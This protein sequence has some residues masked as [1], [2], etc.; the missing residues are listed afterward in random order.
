M[1]TVPVW[2]AICTLITATGCEIITAPDRSQIAADADGDNIDDATDN[3]P[4]I[5]NA[6]QADSDDDGTGD[7]CTEALTD[8]DGDEVADTLDNCPD[9]ANADQLDTDDDD[10]GDTC[11]ADDD[12]DGLSDAD[13]AEAGTDPLDSDSD[14]DSYSDNAELQ[15]GS[16]PLDAAS[17]PSNVDDQDGDGKVDAQDNC[18]A[19]ANANQLDTDDDE[20]G[21]A[22][23]A[24]D[25]NDG[26]LDNHDNC[27]LTAN[28]N[29]ANNDGDAQGDLCDTNDDNDAMPDLS[30]PFPLDRDNDTIND[31]DD[32]CKLTANLSQANFDED[33]NGDA[34]DTDDDNDG[35]PDAQD[36][37]PFDPSE[38]LD[39][40]GDTLGNNADADDDNDGLS[41]SQESLEGSDPLLTDTDSDGFSD[42]IEVAAGTDPDDAADF[43]SSV[44]DQD[45]DGRV[46]ALDNCPQ[47][48][49]VNQYNH[50]DDLLGDACDSDDDNDSVSDEQEAL[51]GSNPI[52]VDTDADGLSDG[53]E[54]LY[55]TNPAE[56][57][58]DNDLLHD[59][60]EIDLLT[61]PLDPDTD[62]DAWGDGDEVNFDTDP[63]NPNSYPGAP[64][65]DNDGDSLSNALE[66]AIGTNPNDADS[67]NDNWNDALEYAEGTDPMDANDYPGVDTDLD[68]LSDA[69][70]NAYATDVS[71]TDTDDDGLSDGWEVNVSGTDPLD[72][73][74]PAPDV[75]GDGLTE[76]QENELGTNPN[77]LDTDADGI[78]DG[79]ESGYGTDATVADTDGD[80]HSDGDEVN[81][82]WDP[83]VP[84]SDNDGLTND[85]EGGY[86]TDPFLSDS[87]A[88]GLTDPDELLTYAT[89]A[90][91][92]DSDND[93]YSDGL[94]VNTYDTDPLNPYDPDGDTDADGLFDNLESSYGT[95]V[96]D[97]D[98]DDDGLN[99]GDEVFGYS[100]DP[101]EADTDGD[102][103][104]D[105]AE[106]NVHN[107]DPLDP[108]DYPRTD[109]FSENG[110]YSCCYEHGEYLNRYGID[111]PA[112][113][114]GWTGAF[115]HVGPV[116]MFTLHTHNDSDIYWYPFT[117]AT[118][119]TQIGVATGDWNQAA[120][121]FTAAS[122][123]A[124]YMRSSG[125]WDTHSMPQL[126]GSG[127]Q[128]I[129]IHDTPMPHTYVLV[130]TINS[131][132]C[133]PDDEC[134]DVG[135]AV[136]I[137]GV[138]PIFASEVTD[139]DTDG[140]FANIETLY[141]LSDTNG[142]TDGDA[143]GD[144]R[145]L[146]DGAV[147]DDDNDGLALWQELQY[148]T[149]PTDADT[150]DDTLNDGDEVLAGYDPTSATSPGLDT[151]SDGLYDFQEASYGGDVSDADTDNDGLSDGDEVLYGTGV[152]VPDSDD[153]GL[154][155]SNEVY[156]YSTNPLRS[157][158][159]YDGWSDYDEVDIGTDPLNPRDFYG[160]LAWDDALA[161][162]SYCCY[163][164][165]YLTQRYPYLNGNVP[166]PMIGWSGL[167]V[168][169]RAQIG[170]YSL[171]VWDWNGGYYSS[172]SP[173]LLAGIQLPI[174]QTGPGP[175]INP[176]PAP[177]GL[178]EG[179]TSSQPQ[180]NLPAA[181][182]VWV[183]PTLE[184]D[185][186]IVAFVRNSCS[187]AS[188][189]YYRG[190][191]F[192]LRGARPL[193]Y[194]QTDDSD[195]DQ[196]LNPAE[197][198]YGGATTSY[199]TDGDGFAD[200][201]EAAWGGDLT[202]PAIPGPDT[203]G[204]Y[205]ADYFEA[206]F[207]T[208]VDDMD[209]D[210]DGL[211]DADEVVLWHSNPLAGDSDGDGFSDAVEVDAGMDPG[212]PHDSFQ[213]APFNI[214]DSAY[215]GDYD[216]GEWGSRYGLSAYTLPPPVQGWSG[217]FERI[218]TVVRTYALHT[219]NG[220]TMYWYSPAVP[221]NQYPI[222][223]IDGDST[224]G[225]TFAPTQRFGMYFD[226]GYTWQ[227]NYSQYALGHSPDR[228][229]WLYPT[230][231]ADTWVVA[232][233][234]DDCTSS[235]Q[236]YEMAGSWEIKGVRPLLGGQVLDG[237]HDGLLDA[238]EDILGTNKA[239]RDSDG[240]RIPD[241]VEVILH[242][243]PLDATAD[244]DGD[245][246]SDA[247]EIRGNSTDPTQ[248]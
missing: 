20:A 71:D 125:Y 147:G 115:R 55:G 166:A 188:T 245:G 204:D 203:D 51:D 195:D 101:L 201:F 57:D 81:W 181:E 192:E 50:D 191:V 167:L 219:H 79:D 95:D 236:C 15:A 45:S 32:N 228:L 227:N 96:S 94:E 130:Y 207:G 194:G 72:P 30:D 85:E 1:R 110:P 68:G 93:S 83:L 176:G 92:S 43:P 157:D 216:H 199:D 112:P 16:D 149:D 164:T 173:N 217:L 144:L 100:T 13:E 88:D 102:T 97:S 197:A 47:V 52:V 113:M 11:D 6:D 109:P 232:V 174:D 126:N 3:C 155:D 37:F 8:A 66:A 240:D 122:Q 159:D 153:D 180:L 183:Y 133:L 2:V 78:W 12:N 208:Y 82:G 206:Q 124:I 170:V 239:S 86:G 154:S 77:L 226:T 90:T 33:A 189:C 56:V 211:W 187:I 89:F 237:D 172:E 62:A 193:S 233:A 36:A 224:S 76:A 42:A 248:P 229:V 132:S 162:N 120:N 244:T 171:S 231:V 177:F 152:T 234:Y 205:L 179:F 168:Q 128:W 58:T 23:D 209:T 18:P 106:I 215:G 196:L 200:G 247:T 114:H 80:T 169:T 151:D 14:D 74:D 218:T 141:G 46:D 123:F 178:R 160:A 9:D 121:D 214:G 163:D 190:A 59:G 220:A 116:A 35:S 156:T 140:V 223:W 131:D 246:T 41:D 5:A 17:T 21:D 119:Q 103:Y 118:Q 210:L 107:T 73:L 105:W 60:D 158:S 182:R 61:D 242:L 230:P 99:D 108:N 70:E 134:F 98:S 64:E 49:N 138:E 185:V 148:S 136:E 198:T 65:P 142:N 40:D 184:T 150:D 63:L 25:D 67:D 31:A 127:H 10:A 186:V 87:D 145:E 19:V 241:G 24:D 48:H 39:T 84:D 143:F 117:T 44:E 221:A 202:N 165:D 53:A 137:K 54:K 213:V 161:N 212:N 238:T 38:Q 28:A 26:D 34:C 225:P 243:A 111:P 135:G 7:A 27:P 146:L 22:C 75:D 222:G 4:A 175:S 91:D 104:D 235:D 139:D 69:A 29:Q 129:W